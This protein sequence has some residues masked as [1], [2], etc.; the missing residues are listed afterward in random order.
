LASLR[1]RATGGIAALLLVSL[2]ALAA[3][4]PPEAPRSPYPW[5]AAYDAKE[6]VKSRIAPPAGFEREAAARGSFAEWLR[7]LPLKKGRPAVRLFDGRL[8]GNQDAH[9]AVVDIDTGTKDLQQ[10]ADAV[11][12]LR[13]EYLFAGNAVAAIHFAFT[14]GDI[15][16]FEKWA[17]GFRPSVNGKR[18]TWAKTAKTDDSYANFRAYLETVFQFAGTASLGQELQKRDVRDLRAGDVFV[19]GGYPGHAVI[20]IDTAKNPKTGRR[21]FLLAQSYMPAQDIHIVR[22]P[23][24]ALSPWYDADIGSELKTPEWTFRP[25]HL[26]QL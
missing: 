26:R 18:V 2:S 3:A 22:N 8:K 12:R 4:L 25:E 9:V 10:C 16:Y 23:A 14:S 13:A 7:D 15:A 21:V 1:E 5:L 20:V 11:M 19:D 6:S 24:G 17:E